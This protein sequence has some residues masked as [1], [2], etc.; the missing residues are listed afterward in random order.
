[1]LDLRTYTRKE[2]LEIYK[3]DRLDCIKAK[4]K[5]R[6]YEYTTNGRGDSLTLTITKCP[7]RFREFCIEK[8]G[9][10]PQTDFKKLKAFMTRLLLDDEFRRLP[11][12]GMEKELENDTY[13]SAQTIGKCARY[14]ENENITGRGDWIYY[15]I[16]NNK[17]KYCSEITRE[18]YKEAWCI[19]FDNIEEEYSERFGLMCHSIGGYPFKKEEIL[20][21][22]FKS[23]VID[24]LIKILEEEK[25]IDES[26]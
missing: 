20:L 12:V 8:L 24:E 22:A 23:D 11:Y 3:T 15:A 1:M 25:Q 14:L 5:R 26:K 16:K 10:A 13:I 17:T 9:F 7:P 6:G 18:E 4:I 21:N 2:L 19:Y